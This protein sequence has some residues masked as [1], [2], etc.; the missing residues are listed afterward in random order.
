VRKNTWS[1]FFT[2]ALVGG[3]A[4]A[5]AG[6]LLSQHTMHLVTA[7]VGLVDRRL[8]DAEREKIRFDLLLQ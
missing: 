2:G 3:L 4:G 5:V 7:F 1:P 6:T 8:T